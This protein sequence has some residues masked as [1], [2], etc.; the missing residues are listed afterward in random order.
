M[1]LRSIYGTIYGM[2]RSLILVLI[3]L[4][5]VQ[6]GCIRKLWKDTPIEDKVFDVYGT[7]QLI[8]DAQIVVQTEQGE[9]PF[10]MGSASIKGADFDLG[11]YVHVYYKMKGKLKEVTMVVEKIK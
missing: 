1:T 5:T 11:A 6:M 10:V 7:V 9:Q 4:S 2:L 3:L 8:N